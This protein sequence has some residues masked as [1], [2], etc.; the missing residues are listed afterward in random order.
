MI[1]IPFRQLEDEVIRPEKP[2]CPITAYVVDQYQ[3]GH[4]NKA[5]SRLEER[6]DLTPIDTHLVA[7]LGKF[8]S[9]RGETAD[10][11]KQFSLLAKY[12]PDAAW[13]F[14]LL[15]NAL[16]SSGKFKKAEAVFTRGIQIDPSDASIHNNLAIVYWKAGSR[17]QAVKQIQQ[18]ISLSPLNKDIVLNCASFLEQLDMPQQAVGLLTDYLVQNFDQ[19][20][21]EEAERLQ[22]KIEES[23][24]KKAVA[25]QFRKQVVFI[26]VRPRGREAKLAYGIKKAG[27][28][29]ILLYREEPNFDISPFFDEVKQYHDIATAHSIAEGYAPCIFHVFSTMVDDVSISFVKHKPGIVVFDPNDVFEGTIKDAFHKIPMQKYCIENADA[30]CCRDLQIRHVTRNVGYQCPDK[31]IFFPEYCWDFHQEQQP[32]SLDGRKND[33]HVVSIGNF[34]IEKLG[35]EEWGYFEIARRFAQ[36]RVHFHIYLHWLWLSVPA[37]MKNDHLSDYIELSKTS[38]FFHLHPTVP[39]DKLIQEISQYDFGVNVIAAKITGKQIKKY[40]DDHFRN[41]LSLRNIDY[42]DAGLPIIIS[43]ELTFQRF[44]AR[45]YGFTIDATPELLEDTK[46]V[47]NR[48]KSP[49]IKERVRRERSAYSVEKQSG[50]LVSFYASLQS[51]L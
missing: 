36:Q 22:L 34:G 4:I 32:G 16:C 38:D 15:G 42:L 8:Y 47:L 48:Y 50:R 25:R 46:T 20:V 28:K 1:S 5:I 41:C 23:R 35:E 44:I 2:G 49:D 30:L 33:I 51:G 39:M 13:V 45:K 19:Q 26:C 43:R 17:T 11:V 27:W 7:M 31:T 40:N 24:L 37:A 21:Q 10:A 29:V 3:K 9:L 14:N 12:L 18:A 6:A